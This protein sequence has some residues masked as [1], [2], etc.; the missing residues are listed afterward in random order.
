MILNVHTWTRIGRINDRDPTR[1]QQLKQPL[2]AAQKQRIIQTLNNDTIPD[3]LTTEEVEWL[4]RQV[5]RA[6]S[7]SLGPALPSPSQRH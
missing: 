5:Q 6:V 3:T 7:R 2:T 1:F 4:D